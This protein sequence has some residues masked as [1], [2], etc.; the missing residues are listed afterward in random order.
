[1]Y[2]AFAIYVHCAISMLI[3][4]VPFA[5]RV[6]YCELC[7]MHLALYAVH[8][9]L[10][11]LIRCAFNIVCFAAHISIVDFAVTPKLA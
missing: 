10:S 8:F 3:K 4:Y 2:D 6:V 9:S 1:M 11:I 7:S 5:L